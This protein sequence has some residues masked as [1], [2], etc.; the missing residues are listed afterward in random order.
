[1]ARKLD[2]PHN[3]VSAEA[4]TFSF[5]LRMAIEHGWDWVIVEGDV[6]SIVNK[7][8]KSQEDFSVIGL[9]LDKAQHT[10]ARHPNFTV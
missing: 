1:M 7:L 3:S 6:I 5:G 10:L 4:T 8:S 9:L 2:T